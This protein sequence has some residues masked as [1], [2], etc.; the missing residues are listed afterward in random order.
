[1]KESSL[2]AGQSIDREAVAVDHAFDS[3]LAVRE[4]LRDR[5]AMAAL[6]GILANPKL[7]DHIENIKNAACDCYRWADAMMTARGMK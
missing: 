3:P 7:P 2:N 5:F 1:M 4:T 6:A